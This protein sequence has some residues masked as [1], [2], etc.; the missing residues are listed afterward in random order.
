MHSRIDLLEEGL[1]N[2]T[3]EPWDG[4][5]GASVHL[6]DLDVLVEGAAGRYGKDN[7]VQYRQERAEFIGTKKSD[8]TDREQRDDARRVYEEIIKQS[9]V[10]CSRETWARICDNWDKAFGLEHHGAART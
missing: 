4:G 3:I 2:H 7:P 8:G 1:E 9:T 10:P 6:V 5:H